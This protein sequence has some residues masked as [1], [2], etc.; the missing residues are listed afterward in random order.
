MRIS[1]RAAI[2]SVAAL[3][4]V[5]GLGTS[6][7]EAQAQGGQGNIKLMI[8]TYRVKPDMVQTWLALEKNDVVPALKKAG[9]KSRQVYRTVI[10]ETNEFQAREPVAGIVIFD[11]PSP[12]VKV[13]GAQK[14]AALEAKLSDCLES[15]HREFENRVSE[16]F[17]DPGNA[18]IQFASKYRPL[19]G[20][21]FGYTQFY[22][23]YMNPVAKQAKKDG[24]FAG[25]DYTVSQHGGEWGLITLNMYYDD[26]APLDGEPPIAKTL[27]PEKTREV[28]AHGQGLI[29]PIEWIVR[30]RVADISF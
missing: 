20:K 8:T 21:S 25:M 23:E 30:Q 2:G 11:G 29:D 1:I 5:I 15:V 7:A 27:G 22:R 13:L 12:L 26:F 4:L 18:P 10:G 9:V 6:L 17:V 3:L 28:L 19:P 16:F 24:T 14:A